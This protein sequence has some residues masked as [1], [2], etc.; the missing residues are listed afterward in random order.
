[1]SH[2]TSIIHL[3]EGLSMDKTGWIELERSVL[4]RTAAIIGE[5]SAAAAA[6]AD[7]DAH[8]GD[9]RFWKV[10]GGYIVV[11]KSPVRE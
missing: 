3:N 10:P 11:E 9:A 6:M 4:E 7:A 2:K 1:M 5:H 8:K